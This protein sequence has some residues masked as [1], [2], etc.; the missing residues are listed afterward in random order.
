MSFH[1]SFILRNISNFSSCCQQV[2]KSWGC[3]FWIQLC[4]TILKP[5]KSVR[6]IILQQ[7]QTVYWSGLTIGIVALWYN[8]NYR[9][10]RESLLGSAVLGRCTGL[11]KRGTF[12]LANKKSGKYISATKL[13]INRFKPLS[14]GD[15]VWHT[16]EQ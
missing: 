8:S 14:V 10:I 3:L 16:S 5:N 9:N 1:S 7:I 11:I 13:D 2:R 15:I 4:N 6:P 12:W